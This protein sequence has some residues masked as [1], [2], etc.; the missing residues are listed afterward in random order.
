MFSPESKKR[1]IFPGTVHKSLKILRFYQIIPGSNCLSIHSNWIFFHQIH[2]TEIKS[3]SMEL[4]ASSYPL[5]AL[6]VVGATFAAGWIIDRFSA[7]HLLRFFL[8]PLAFG[9]L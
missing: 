5:F 7:V 1:L 9:L 6:S 2:L 4:L 3:W 8:L